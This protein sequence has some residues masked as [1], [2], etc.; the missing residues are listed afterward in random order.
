M[1]TCDKYGK[2]TEEFL[3]EFREVTDNLLFLASQQVEK[4][5]KKGICPKMVEKLLT[6]TVSN[7]CVMGAMKVQYADAT[8]DQK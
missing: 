8:K 2:F 7:G 6:E 1:Q 5:I 4:A 3:D